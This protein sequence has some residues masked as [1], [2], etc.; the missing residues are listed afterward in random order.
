MTTP[1][2]SVSAWSGPNAPQ[3]PR[4]ISKQGCMSALRND[5]GCVQEST[6]EGIAAA[7][8]F[9]SPEPKLHDAVQ[10]F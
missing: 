5:A 3:A 8:C 4:N 9:L 7:V 6:S 10:P 1:G 2:M